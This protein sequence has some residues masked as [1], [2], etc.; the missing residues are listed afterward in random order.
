MVGVDQVLLIVDGERFK[1]QVGQ[2]AIGGQEQPL[3]RTESR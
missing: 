2:V 1:G 3:A